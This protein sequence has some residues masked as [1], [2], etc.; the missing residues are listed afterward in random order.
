[1]KQRKAF[2]NKLEGESIDGAFMLDLP[3]FDEFEK[4]QSHILDKVSG[5]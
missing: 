1:M 4:L 3:G 2:A 5:K